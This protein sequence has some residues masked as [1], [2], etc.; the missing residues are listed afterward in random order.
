MDTIFAVIGVT[1]IL[2]VFLKPA[3]FYASGTVELIGASDVFVL[4]T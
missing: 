3:I 4:F 1:A 2:E